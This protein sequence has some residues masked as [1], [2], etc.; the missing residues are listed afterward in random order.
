LDF[1]PDEL[2]PSHAP[3]EILAHA[4]P[5]QA[6]PWDSKYTKAQR[7][8]MFADNLT[9]T[10]VPHT[11]HNIT[12][13]QEQLKWLQLWRGGAPIAF[14]DVAKKLNIDNYGSIDGATYWDRWVNE[15]K[16]KMEMQMQAA[17]LAKA[18]GLD[19]G[20]DQ[21]GAGEKGGQKGTGGR[22]PSGQK[23]PKIKQKTSGPGGPRTVVSESG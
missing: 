7:A 11:Q 3:D 14:H 15:Q 2:I 16:I 21:H 18:L 1:N 10:V 8:Q 12:Q 4:D 23:S 6:V 22:A 20:D 17:A 9:L 13:M 19:G 5:E